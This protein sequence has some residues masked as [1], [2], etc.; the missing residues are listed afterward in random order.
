MHDA[1]VVVVLAAAT[2]RSQPRVAGGMSS[3]AEAHC[4]GVSRNTCG[5]LLRMSAGT[6]GIRRE[7]VVQAV[8]EW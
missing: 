8:T 2:G 3:L 7:L 1:V 5:C 6:T 4:Q